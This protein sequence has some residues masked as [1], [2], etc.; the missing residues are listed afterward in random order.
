MEGR[1]RVWL[2]NAVLF[3]AIV[4]LSIAVTINFRPLYAFFV[5]HYRLYREVG[6]TRAQ[7]MAEYGRLLDYLN[8]PWTGRLQL[9]LPMSQSGMTHFA[10]CRKLFLLD[11][12]VCLLTVPFAVHYVRRLMAE[13]QTWR[14]INPISWCFA[15][16]FMIG[17]FLVSDFEDFF[18]TFHEILFRNS[19]WIFDPD[20]DPIILALPS[21]FFMACFGMFII[22][23]VLLQGLLLWRGRWELKHAAED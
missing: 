11:Y 15:V 10:D 22:L 13:R 6:L 4:S 3:L 21:E 14:L 5:D 1:V 12:A 7:L 19:D 18:V 16:I 9:S 17:V 23:F 2:K 8:L 20:T